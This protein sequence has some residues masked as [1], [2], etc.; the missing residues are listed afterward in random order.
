MKQDK[1]GVYVDAKKLRRCLHAAQFCMTKADRIIYSTPALIACGDII[2]YFQLAYDIP[3]QRE[4]YI[5]MFIKS[6]AVLRADIEEMFE[7]E[8]IRPSST[9]AIVMNDKEKESVNGRQLLLRIIELL[10]RIDEGINKWRLSLKAGTRP[11]ESQPAA[12]KE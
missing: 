8:I 3:E 10:A 4:Y 9:T 11:A 6:F 12:P 1:A 2:G 7:L 5:H